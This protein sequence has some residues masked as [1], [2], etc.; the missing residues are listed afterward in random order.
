MS[1]PDQQHKEEGTDWEPWEQPL[2]SAQLIKGDYHSVPPSGTG[3]QGFGVKLHQTRQA[4]SLLTFLDG[5]RTQREVLHR[6]YF[7][8]QPFASDTPGNSETLR[9]FSTQHTGFEGS[10]LMYLHKAGTLGPCM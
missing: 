3:V 4:S 1:L 6:P 10:F 9:I 7:T 5:Q 8:I 2:C